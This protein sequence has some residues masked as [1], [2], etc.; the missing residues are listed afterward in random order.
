MDAQILLVDDDEV[1]VRTVR[2]AFRRQG[3]AQQLLVAR[4]GV[5]ALARLRTWSGSSNGPLLILL[6]LNM[7]QMNGFE[8]L[9]QLRADPDLKR[10]V[11]F[12]LSTSEEV[13]DIRSAYDRCAAGYMMKSEIGKNPKILTELLSSYLGAVHLPS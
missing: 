8:F 9:D 5:E 6:D 10:H 7:P 4:N 12:V 3:R 13:R 1:D 11:V 2:R